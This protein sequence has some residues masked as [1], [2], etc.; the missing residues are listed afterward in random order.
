[1]V[2]SMEPMARKLLEFGGSIRLRKGSVQP[3]GKEVRFDGGEVLPHGAVL[4][5]AALQ[6]RSLGQRN[7]T[8]PI[9]V[10][11]APSPWADSAW[12]TSPIRANREVA[13][14][15]IIFFFRVWWKLLRGAER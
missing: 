13:G 8:G 11:S 7:A 14:L 3:M 1:M 9:I 15:K 10:P 5:K 12:W 6:G 2:S 4:S